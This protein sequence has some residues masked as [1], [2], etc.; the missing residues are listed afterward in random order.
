MPIFAMG[1]MGMK[2][3]VFSR[4]CGLIVGVALVFTANPALASNTLSAQECEQ[5]FSENEYETAQVQS[6]ELSGYL[7]FFYA[8]NQ[9]YCHIS[10]ALAGGKNIENAALSVRISNANRSYTVQFS[11]ESTDDFPCGIT[12]YFSSATRVGQDIYFMLDFSEKE[13][14]NVRNNADIRL[15]ANE[16][17]YEIAHIEAPYSESTT[18]K[19]KSL[20]KVSKEKS[21]AES[22]TK[23]VYSGSGAQTNSGN[24]NTT[25]FQANA[26]QNDAYQ[27]GDDLQEEQSESRTDEGN[28]LSVPVEKE[29]DYSPEA[30]GMFV[31]AGLFAAVGAGLL[32]RRAIK[33][34]SATDEKTESAEDDE[35]STPNEHT[36]TQSEIFD[37]DE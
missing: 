25:K 9:L 12:K 3:A 36:D 13:D 23:F 2:S 7:R 26:K 32:I 18:A 5:W 4:F 10:Y 6:E 11:S 30:K 28:V 35:D 31:L 21:T 34:R 19:E 29:T 14:K 22:T 24:E 27:S 20:P 16:K 15:V 17:S 37:E 8:Q 33:S 1:G